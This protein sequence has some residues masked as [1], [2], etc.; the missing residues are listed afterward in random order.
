MIIGHQKII[1]FLDESVERDSLSQAYLFSGPEH[2]GKFTV[3]SDFAEKL[4]G[5]TG[6]NIN[7]DLIIVAPETEEKK[8]SV[9]KKD[10]KVEQIRELQK[11]LS[12][13][14]SGRGK[15][16][17]IIDEADRLTISAQNALLKTLEEPNDRSVIIL[18][19]HDPEKILP[20]IKSRCLV[21]NFQPVG[22]KELSEVI[23]AENDTHE[24]I[25]WSAGRPGL[26]LELSRDPEKRRSFQKYQEDFKKILTGNL[27][28]KFSLAEELG[29]DAPRAAEE[30]KAWTVLFRR[31]MLA[32]NSSQNIDREKS[33]EL[34]GK[35]SESLRFLKETNAS[36][37]VVLENLFLRF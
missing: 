18:V 14:P 36:S 25:F 9:K 30:L 1:N 12:R 15:K 23:G 34:I 13:S 3:A 6:K 26:A 4:T 7:A 33:L 27:A 22:E 37:R 21:K 11:E 19:A 29:K 24:L 2:L 10:I 8:G 16:V 20:T 32:N 17:A 5:G 28:E 35:I 31:N